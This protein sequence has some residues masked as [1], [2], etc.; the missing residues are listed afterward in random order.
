MDV[1]LLGVGMSASSNV[2]SCES[3]AY[4]GLPGN[5][6]SHYGEST[7]RAE[8]LAGAGYAQPYP[9][10]VSDDF[11]RTVRLQLE[12]SRVSEGGPD[13]CAEDIEILA[14]ATFE[15]DRTRYRALGKTEVCAL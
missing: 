5:G 15:V 1:R 11:A 4:I 13:V 7:V 2:S 8:A 10:L 12:M 14:E 6:C 3:C 9:T